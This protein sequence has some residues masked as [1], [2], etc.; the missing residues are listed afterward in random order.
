MQRIDLKSLNFIKNWLLNH[1]K[2]DICNIIISE[3]ENFDWDII[4]Q[5][6]GKNILA[7]V[8]TSK[9]H[10]L[11]VSGNWNKFFRIDNKHGLFGTLKL[12][13]PDTYDK[14]HDQ[15]CYVLNASAGKKQVKL[16]PKCKWVKMKDTPNSMLIY[17]GEDGVCIWNHE[18]IMEG[19]LGYGTIFCPKTTEFAAR[20]KSHEYKALISLDTATYFPFNAR[21]TQTFKSICK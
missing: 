20:W 3:Q 1:F 2:E 14:L 4:I 18:Q 8:K 10:P 5:L 16:S 19:F 21:E 12:D 13:K 9:S 11:K 7:E 6:K 15:Y 17:I